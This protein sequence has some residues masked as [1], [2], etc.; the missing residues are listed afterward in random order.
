MHF[1]S[2]NGLEP[3]GH[4]FNEHRHPRNLFRSRWLHFNTE[5]IEETLPFTNFKAFHPLT[6]SCGFTLNS[7]YLLHSAVR[8]LSALKK[9]DRSDITRLGRGGPVKNISSSWHFSQTAGIVHFEISGYDPLFEN[10]SKACI[11][12]VPY[13]KSDHKDVW[14]P[15]ITCFW[16]LP[17]PCEGGFWSTLLA[18]LWETA[19]QSSK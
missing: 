9:Q 1:V 8:Y 7:R 4:N 6:G 12:S 18:G 15:L 3:L 5:G 2:E 19:D 14:R 13:Q 10:V 16:R 11:V 17:C